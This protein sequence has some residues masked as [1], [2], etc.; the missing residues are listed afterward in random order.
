MY[1]SV[2]KELT[3][4]CQFLSLLLSF[5][6]YKHA[7]AMF[8]QMCEREGKLDYLNISDFSFYQMSLEHYTNP[9]KVMII[10]LKISITLLDS[11]S[12]LVLCSSK[13]CILKLN[14]QRDG[15]WR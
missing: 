12:K 11:L 10:F 14:L 7:N 9:G 8:L 6:F 4:V 2:M 1:Q 3:D 13:I 5:N 15:I